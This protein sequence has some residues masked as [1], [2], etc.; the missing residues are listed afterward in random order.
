M[1]NIYNENDV[2]Y[3]YTYKDTS[4]IIITKNLQ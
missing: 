2:F 1:T 3:L 4:V